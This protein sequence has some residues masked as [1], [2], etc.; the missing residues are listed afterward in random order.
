MKIFEL[1]HCDNCGKD[2]AVEQK[3][4]ETHL[5]C[6]YCWFDEVLFPSG[7]TITCE[8]EDQ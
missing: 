2:F 7:K 3:E 1:V 5:T 6:P 8:V 4:I